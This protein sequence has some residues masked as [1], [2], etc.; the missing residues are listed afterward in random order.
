MMAVFLLILLTVLLF[1][2]KDPYEM[3][4][5]MINSAPSFA[6]LFGTDAFGR[7]LLSRTIVGLGYSLG[8]MLMALLIA[9]VI[10]VLVGLASSLLPRWIGDWFMV[11]LDFLN[12]LPSIVY[13]LILASLLEPTI[14]TLA[15]IIGCCSWMTMARQVRMMLL[16]EKQ[17]AYVQMAKQIETTPLHRVVNYF[18]PAIYP[19]VAVTAIHEAIHIVL[20]EATIS[21]LGLGLPVNTPTLGNLLMDAQN[22]F[23][24]G[25][26][27]NVLF[28]GLFIGAIVMTLLRL[29]ERLV[30]GGDSI[31]SNK[32]SFHFLRW[33]KDHTKC[34]TQLAKRSNRRVN[35]QKWDW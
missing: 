33:P 2:I 31:D 7:D 21:F 8:I 11:V 28:P 18:I 22:Y 30:R 6:H 35:G 16:K 9:I 32:K 24:V 26:W 27:W 29:K 3:F 20:A 17:Q 1:F 13:I 19:V 4:G 23:L 34:N 10:G 25:A 15:F 14:F 5:N 12:S